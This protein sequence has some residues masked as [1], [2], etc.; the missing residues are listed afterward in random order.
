[1][2]FAEFLEFEDFCK[3]GVSGG[4]RDKAELLSLVG[5]YFK[6]GDALKYYMLVKYLELDDFDDD[7]FSR[8]EAEYLYVMK[9]FDV[10]NLRSEWHLL[11]S[12]LKE[13]RGVSGDNF[14]PSVVRAS[15]LARFFP[16]KF[17]AGRVQDIEKVLHGRGGFLKVDKI[18]SKVVLWARGRFEE[19]TQK[20]NM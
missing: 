2:R 18:F 1:M 8:G 14:H 5:Y 20:L 9:E 19:L 16:G 17:G 3:R 13:V 7:L 6:C 10:V 4:V 12:F 11:S 15:L